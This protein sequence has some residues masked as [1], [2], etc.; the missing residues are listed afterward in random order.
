MEMTIAWSGNHCEG[1]MNIKVSNELGSEGVS[2]KG[3]EEVGEVGS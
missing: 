3:T 1:A 2:E